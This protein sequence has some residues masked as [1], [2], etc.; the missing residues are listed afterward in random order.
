MN[1]IVL[2]IDTLRQ[3]HVG[4]YHKGNSVFDGIAPCQTPNIDRFAEDCVVFE[5]MYPEALP[6][7]PVRASLFTGQ[8]TLVS[9][10]WQRLAD[11][12]ISISEIL[13][14]NGWVCGIVSDNY[15]FRSPNMN[16]HRAFHSYEWIHGQEYDPYRSSPPKHKNIDD[17]VNEHYDESWRARVAQFLT[18]TEDFTS[19]DHWFAAQIADRTVKWL[20]D[21]RSHDKIFFWVD[22]FD[23]HEP[24]DP[25]PKFDKYT[26]PNYSGK[27][28]ILPKGGLAD[29]WASPEE[30]NHIRGLYAG[31]TESVDHALGRVFTT[32]EQQGYFEDSIVVLI[33]D[34]GMPLGDHGKF[35]KGVD[36]LYNELLKVPFMIRMPN[37][38]HGG[39]T[40]QALC[41]F[42][43]F[44]PTILDL[45][46]M[47]NC[48][49]YLPGKSF[50]EIITGN[51]ENHRHSI[52]TGYYD[53][54]DRAIRT[55][56][57]NLIIRPPGQ[58][59]ELY[60]QQQDP[61]EG[62]NLAPANPDL[63]S[64]LIAKYGSIYYGSAWPG[65]DKLAMPLFVQRAI[66]DH[67]L[68]QRGINVL[69]IP[70]EYGLNVDHQDSPE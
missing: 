36:R 34:H 27:R 38:K 9:R 68:Q 25:P 12:D 42:N 11:E 35:L 18:N 43:D 6:T 33:G 62:T 23:P 22:S 29:D 48:T 10:A 64:K 67:A 30:I 5:N 7:I 17:Y 70:G 49:E 19:E 58:Q 26:D 8:R 65:Q 15:H 54:Q 59:H 60:N 61:R 55:N 16:Y 50:A 20:S 14:P 51:V 45:M 1:L 37:G 53:G 2:T 47:N 57:W 56:E 3:D 40:V 31:E 41:Q 46:G 4:A 63:V 21:N 39:R 28:L 32:L 69:G 52:M 24:W 44:M 13:G 66:G